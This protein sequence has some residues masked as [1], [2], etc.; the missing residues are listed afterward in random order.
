MFEL[1]TWISA[2]KIKGER[3]Q[4]CQLMNLEM[5]FV[6]CQWMNMQCKCKARFLRKRTKKRKASNTLEEK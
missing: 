1:R 2:G 4:W 5:C 6:N 3:Q